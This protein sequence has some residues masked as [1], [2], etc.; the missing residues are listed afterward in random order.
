MLTT[1]KQS[2]LSIGVGDLLFSQ[3]REIKPRWQDNREF[4]MDLS[5]KAKNKFDAHGRNPL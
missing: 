1:K 4:I 3:Q 2:Q 5:M